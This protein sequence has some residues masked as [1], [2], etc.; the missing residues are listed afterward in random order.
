MKMENTSDLSSFMDQLK[1]WAKVHSDRRIYETIEQAERV[2]FNAS[3]L[4]VRY[5][6]TLRDLRPYMPE[7]LPASFRDHWEMAIKIG[8]EAVETVH[9]PE[10]KRSI[11]SLG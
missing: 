8:F 6:E 11:F 4:I 3:E 9:Y 1:E 5:A 7:S 10:K 2:S